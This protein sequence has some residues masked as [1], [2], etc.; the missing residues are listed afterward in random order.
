MSQ[1]ATSDCRVLVLGKTG[2][3]KSSVCNALLGREEFTVGRGMASTT[4][5]TQHATTDRNGRVVTVVDTPDL[6]Y[7]EEMANSQQGQEEVSRWKSLT[8]PFPSAIL[9]AVRCDVRYTPEEYDI[10][11]RVQIYWGDNAT[12]CSRLIVVFTFLDC[13]DRPIAEELR[14]VCPELKKVLKEA[15]NRYVVFN[16]NRIGYEE[17]LWSSIER[18]MSA[19][20]NPKPVESQ[21]ATSRIRPSRLLVLLL[22]ILLAL[23]A[24]SCIVF[25]AFRITDAAIAVG[26]VGIV[27]AGVLG[28]IMYSRK[29]VR[30]LV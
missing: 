16:K 27:V 25:V 13:Q 9:I 1:N 30:S 12:F 20:V 17:L 15:D 8:T 21:P 29:N 11:R 2:N 22:A 28:A 6:T 23:L 18:H 7:T 14:T 4:L 10:Y 26:V 24:G 5:K 3:G 19:M